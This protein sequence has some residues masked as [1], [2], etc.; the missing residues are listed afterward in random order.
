MKVET[1]FPYL[2]AADPPEGVS[3]THDR[4]GFNRAHADVGGPE[5]ISFLF[6]FGK[7]VAAG[8]V[9]AWLWDQIKSIKGKRGFY[10]KIN[11][12]VITECT[13][14]EFKQEVERSIELEMD[15]QSK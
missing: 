13:E 2:M 4:I 1:T 3:C 6:T 12:R 14:D 11:E 7:S 5:V 15:D 10:M 9:A 8:L